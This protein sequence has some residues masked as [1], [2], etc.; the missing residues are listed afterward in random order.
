M[1]DVAKQIIG[2]EVVVEDCARYEAMKK[3]VNSHIDAA[4]KAH[5]DGDDRA[6]AAQISGAIGYLRAFTDPAAHRPNT[7]NYKEI[8]G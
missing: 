3:R 8:P 7:V 2:E 4:D 5:H 6:A 1:S